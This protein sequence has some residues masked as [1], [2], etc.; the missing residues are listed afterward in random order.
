MHEKILGSLKKGIAFVVSAPAGTG[1]TT[2]A[3]MLVD[4][5]PAV[6]E[7]ISCTTRKMRRGEIADKDYHFLSEEEFAVKVNKHSHL[8]PYEER[9]QCEYSRLNFR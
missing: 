6:T 4:E 8:Y 9:G 1:K 3:H 7:S 5:Y 2:L